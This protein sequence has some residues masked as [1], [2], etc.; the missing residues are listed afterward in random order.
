MERPEKITK[1]AFYL[2]DKEPLFYLFIINTDFIHNNTCFGSKYAAVLYKNGRVNFHYTDAFIQL[3][4]KKLYFILIHEAYHIFKKHLMIHEPL[5]EKNAVLANIAEDAIINSE[6]SESSFVGINPEHKGL[7]PI[8]I[9]EEYKRRYSRLGKDAYVTPRLF[10]WY[11]S[12]KE[13]NKKNLL[14]KNR[15]YKNKK[16]GEYGIVGYPD[17]DETFS[18]VVFDKGFEGLMNHHKDGYSSNEN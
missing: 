18:N 14:E 15:Y 1:L 11:K 5:F 8:F 10:N 7:D 9:P 13:E 4:I 17:G 6:I 2:M 12:K 16:T 3:P